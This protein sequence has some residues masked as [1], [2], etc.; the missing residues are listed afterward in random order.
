MPF[1]LSL[2]LYAIGLI[3][4]FLSRLNKAKLF[5]LSGF[6]F[7]ILI[8]TYPFSNFLIKSLEKEFTK[9]KVNKING[10]EYISVLGNGHN[11]NSSFH[12]MR[13]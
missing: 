1:S 5:L 11:S 12:N 8:T 3:M 7:Q 10:V 9:N 6:I 13:N 2:I 4:L